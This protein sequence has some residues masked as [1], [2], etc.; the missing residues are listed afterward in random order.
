MKKTKFKPQDSL[1]HDFSVFA[2]STTMADYKLAFEL[3]RKF[4]VNFAKQADLPVYVSENKAVNFPFYFYKNDDEAE[5]F[6]IE[7]RTSGEPMMRSFLLFAK[8]HFDTFEIADIPDEISLWDDIFNCNVI[9][10][11]NKKN[12]KSKTTKISRLVNHILSDLEYHLLEITQKEE[13]QKV[14]LKPTQTRSIRK[15]YNSSG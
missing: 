12:K 11:Q 10:F 14:K 1:S 13:D 7:D 9:D 3:N 4:Q 6:L 8:G 2:I 15:L 5:C